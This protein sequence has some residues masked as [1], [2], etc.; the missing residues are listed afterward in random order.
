MAVPV[1]V[2]GAAEDVADD[3]TGGLAGGVVDVDGEGTAEVE[4]CGAVE[5]A[6]G[7]TDL[8]AEVV[9]V[10][11]Q[12]ASITAIRIIPTNAENNFLTLI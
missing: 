12:P 7:E 10:P 8:V 3:A 5:V 9:A 4:D 6:A 11:A 1:A 2:V